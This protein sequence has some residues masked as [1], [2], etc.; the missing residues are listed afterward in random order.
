[1]SIRC[2]AV[3]SVGTLLRTVRYVSKEKSRLVSLSLLKLNVSG[4]S[5]EIAIKMHHLLNN[6]GG[7]GEP[8]PVPMIQEA[9]FWKGGWM[10]LIFT[11]E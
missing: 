3:S 7:R 10:T 9:S 4:L 1:M 6:D 5:S 11:K 8:I 2:V